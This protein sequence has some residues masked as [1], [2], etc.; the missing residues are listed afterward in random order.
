MNQDAGLKHDAG[1]LGDV[2]DEVAVCAYVK[3][4]EGRFLYINRAG[5]EA[6][7]LTPETMIGQAALVAG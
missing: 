7:G 5:A 6:I 1:R 2:M 4:P 3:D